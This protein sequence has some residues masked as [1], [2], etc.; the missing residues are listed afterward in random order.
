MRGQ[1]NAE[2]GILTTSANEASVQRSKRRG[3]RSAKKSW[4]EFMV[5]ASAFPLWRL[6][7]SCV[8]LTGNSTAP[9]TMTFLQ[10][11]SVISIH[12]E[13]F[14]LSRVAYINFQ[15]FYEQGVDSLEFH[16]SV[17]YSAMYSTRSLCCDVLHVAIIRGTYGALVCLPA[18]CCVDSCSNLR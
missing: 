3:S 12:C 14:W 5:M 18:Y 8:Q 17:G 1:G 9:I 15:I 13:R 6:D 7:C 2:L 16:M 11:S 10:K 4:F